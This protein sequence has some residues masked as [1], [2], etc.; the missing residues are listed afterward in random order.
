MDKAERVLKEC[1]DDLLTEEIKTLPN[2]A[3]LKKQHTFSKRFQKNMNRLI[4]E[5]KRKNIYRMYKALDRCN[6]KEYEYF[7]NLTLAYDELLK[8][9]KKL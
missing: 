4:K 2:D 7:R 5:N 8:S 1:I 3:E 9:G 6:V